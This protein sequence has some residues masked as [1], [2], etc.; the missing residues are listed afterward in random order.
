MA[1]D[2]SKP[3]LNG[4]ELGTVRRKE[5][6]MDVS[7]IEKL[8]DLVASV[9]GCIVAYQDQVLSRIRVHVRNLGW[10]E[11]LSTVKTMNQS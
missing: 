1:L 11:T 6:E 5:Q 7:L 8:L 10:E 9:N 2:C 3:K 4:I